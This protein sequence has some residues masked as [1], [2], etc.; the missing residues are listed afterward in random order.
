MTTKAGHRSP[1][2]IVAGILL[3]LSAWGAYA[4]DPVPSVTTSDG[5]TFKD[6]KVFKTVGDKVLLLHSEGT[7]TVPLDALSDD[8]RKSLGLRTRAEQAQFEADQKAKGLV[9]SGRDWLTPEEKQLKDFFATLNNFAPDWKAINF[10][11]QFA[12]WL[13]NKTPDGPTWR[14]VAE[15]AVKA[16]DAEAV[17]KVF[18][19]W[20]TDQKAQTAAFEVYLNNLIPDWHDAVHD[21]Q[22]LAWIGESNPGDRWNKYVLIQQARGR[23]GAGAVANAILTWRAKTGADKMADEVRRRASQENA[24]QDE[25]FR[26]TDMAM[27]NVQTLATQRTVQIQLAIETQTDAIHDHTAAIQSLENPIIAQKAIAPPPPST[28]PVS[29][30][31]SASR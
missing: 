15:A 7:A 14:Q 9:K 22:F 16:L 6:V 1:P 30:D 11:M 29:A 19:T 18:N 28:A 12:A 23:Q 20:K 24:E 3:L 10:N 8:V 2:A 21:P 17:A 27:R 26:L 13:E 5:Q 4:L 31:T 25:K